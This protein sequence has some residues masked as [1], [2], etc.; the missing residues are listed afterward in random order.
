MFH[1]L[2]KNLAIGTWVEIFIYIK[3]VGAKG[4]RDFPMSDLVKN[5]DG[6]DI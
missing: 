6:S 2:C 4:D 3:R 5:P 1:D